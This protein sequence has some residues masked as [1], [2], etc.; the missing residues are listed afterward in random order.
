M[1]GP[2]GTLF[3]PL[4]CPLSK[5][6]GTCVLVRSTVSRSMRRRFAVFPRGHILGDWE[7]VRAMEER[8]VSETEA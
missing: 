8:W 4:P 6:T 1:P 5:S 3:S 7:G 2:T